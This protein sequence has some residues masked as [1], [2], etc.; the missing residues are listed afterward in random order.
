MKNEI[1]EYAEH[2]RKHFFG[3]I[4][5]IVLSALC[6]WHEANFSYGVF[7]GVEHL[8]FELAV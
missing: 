8:G 4:G 5:E 7:E 1:I 6:K 3:K 2:L